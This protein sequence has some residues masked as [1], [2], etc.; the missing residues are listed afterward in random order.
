MVD[1]PSSYSSDSLASELA[2][3]TAQLEKIAFQRDLA[4]QKAERLAVEVDR[5]EAQCVSL[6]ADRDLLQTRLAERDSYLKAIESS[7]GWR[8]MQQLRSIFGR[9]W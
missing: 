4:F 9:R 1:H 2:R 5:L 3:A 7:L 8:M 6:V